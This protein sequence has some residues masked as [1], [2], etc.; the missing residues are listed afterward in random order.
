MPSLNNSAGIEEELFDIYHP[1]FTNDG[2]SGNGLA[3]EGH[4][5]QVLGKTDPHLIAKIT[6]DPEAGAFFA[7]AKD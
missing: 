2:H 6:F 3:W 4:I 1:P 5:V 7:L